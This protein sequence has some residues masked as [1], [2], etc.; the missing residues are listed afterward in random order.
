MA[1]N[2]LK[3]TSLTFDEILTQINDKFNSDPRF[4]NFRES[5]IAQT[6]SEIFAGAVDIVNY[7]LER[8]A[9]ESFFDTARLRSSVILLAR[10]LGYVV[11]RPVPAE[12][13]IKV[14]L[15]DNWSDLGLNAQSTIQVPLHSVFTYGGLSFILKKTLKINF[16][17]YQSTLTADGV[18]T[19]F[20]L[21][22]FENEDIK[23]AQ[24]EIKEK[25]IEG[26]T[27]PQVGSTFQIYRIEDEEFSNRYGGEDYDNPVT[28]VWVG[29]TKS[30]NTLYDINRR[31]LIDWEVI[32]AANAGEVQ[33]VCVVRTAISEGTE[34]LFGDGRFAQVGASTS[35]QGA[36]TTFDNVYI[37]YLATKG[38]EANQVGAKDNKIQFAGKVFDSKGND[39]TDRVEFYFESNIT[40]GADMEDIDSIRVNAPNIYYSLDRLVSKRDYVNYL[41][42]LT[43]PID[44]KNAIAWGEQEE[45][46]ERGLEA[47]IRMFNVVFFSVVGPL[48]QTDISP[49]YVRTKATGLDNAVLDFGYDDDALNQRNYFNV[50][51]KGYVTDS[52]NLVEQLKEYQTTTFRWEIR[53]DELDTTKDGDYY[54]SHYEDNM[55]IVVNYTSDVVANNPS[56]SGSTTLSLN[57]NSLAGESNFDT[58][59]STISTLLQN[60]LQNVDDER[61]TNNFQNGNF[62]N[63]A[64]PDLTVTYNSTTKK[65]T[66]AH[67]LDTPAYIYAL[68]GLSGETDDAASDLGLSSAAS[69]EVT[70]DRELSKKIIT[71]VDDLDKRSQVTIRN[72]YI[73]PIIQTIKLTGNVYI[74]D[75]YDLQTER[76]NVEDAVYDWFND[77][78]DFNNEIYISNVVELVEQFPSVL[79][80]DVRFEP[81]FPVNPNGGNFYD[82]S[83]HPSIESVGFSTSDKE[84][85]YETINERLESYIS[86][87]NTTDTSGSNI[88]DITY[89]VNSS[90]KIVQQYDFQ[91][92]SDI[93]ERTFLEVF[94]KGLYN[95][96]KGDSRFRVFAD[97]DNFINLISDIRKDYLRIIR[98]NLIDTNGNIAK[99]NQ[100]NDDGTAKKGGYSLGSEIVKIDINLSYQYK[101]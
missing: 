57:V 11:Q 87:A 2:F 8:R 29:D 65:I 56:L 75:L 10:G 94:A 36:N 84:S 47:M 37:Q 25:V 28:K 80:A 81:D 64:F 95:E 68:Q 15:K 66:V 17:S 39:V 16:D 89:T 62:G 88:R 14:K 79:Y 31:S 41:K 69:F 49:Y 82:G 98:Y 54:S 32:D 43:T 52:S 9:E 35:G 93:T 27:N 40:G 6:M 1:N 42:S 51:T 24:G 71:V 22:D 13:T 77:N 100:T 85:L 73:S 99:D 90:T 67:G 97:S 63:K 30:D 23:I 78:A 3:Y 20:I 21:K 60:A 5:A 38:S 72:I 19:D 86:S 53:G 101:R 74:K 33:N 46:N 12:A 96:L 76:T 91:W 26:N 83:S 58:T 18:E 48:Y 70:T 34:V 55:P 50:F 4:T 44:I 92:N 45:L 7:Y 61:G 59:M